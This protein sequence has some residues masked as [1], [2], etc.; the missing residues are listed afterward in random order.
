MTGLN[1]DLHRR[2]E[3]ERDNDGT[4]L[5]TER[6]TCHPFYNGTKLSFTDISSEKYRE[7]DF[8]EKGSARIDNPVQLNVSKNGHRVWDANNVSHYI[9][10]G[11]IHIHWEV[12]DGQPNFVK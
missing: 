6:D 1:N 12:K 3:L 11:W 10:M 5:L 7:Y 2:G 9:P 4:P 8:G